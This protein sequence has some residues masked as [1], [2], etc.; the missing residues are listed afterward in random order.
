M[1]SRP[2]RSNLYYLFLADQKAHPMPEWAV[3]KV[4]EKIFENFSKSIKL[5]KDDDPPDI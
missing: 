5:L 1:E 2:E 4:R 3:Q